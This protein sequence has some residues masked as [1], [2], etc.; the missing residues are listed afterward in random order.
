MAPPHIGEQ[1]HMIPLGSFAP[2][3]NLAGAP[4]KVA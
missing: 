3:D 4:A 1:R 2:D